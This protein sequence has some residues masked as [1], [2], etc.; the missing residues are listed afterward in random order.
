MLGL[1]G[2]LRVNWGLAAGILGLEGSEGSS[3]H[4]ELRGEGVLQWVGG[5][6]EGGAARDWGAA[7]CGGVAGGGGDA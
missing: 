5:C 7:R 4:C 6:K 3:C 1:G 2:M